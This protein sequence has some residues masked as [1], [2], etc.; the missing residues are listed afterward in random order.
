MT[1][2][3]ILS[4]I[5]AC[6]FVIIAAAGCGKK[7]NTGDE[8]TQA[9]ETSVESTE[10]GNS[11][12][13]EKPDKSSGKNINGTILQCFAWSFNTISESME[14]IAHAGYAAIQTSPANECI[15]GGNGGMELMGQGKWYYHYQ[16]TDWKIG[17]YQLGTKEEFKAMCEKAHSYGIKVIVDVD[18]SLEPTA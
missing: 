4:L 8:V 16:P 5:L 15:V 17:N 3:K 9:G 11:Q 14:D 1:K 13:T 10:T 2:K 12:S 18:A 6:M 7:N